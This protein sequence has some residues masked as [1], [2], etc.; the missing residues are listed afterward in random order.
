MLFYGGKKIRHKIQKSSIHIVT[1]AVAAAVF[2]LMLCDRS[3]F[4][5]GLYSKGC[6]IPLEKDHVRH[7]G[8]LLDFPETHVE[9]TSADEILM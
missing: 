5:T 8:F 2:N 3:A 6:W 4:P 9:P 7:L 1:N